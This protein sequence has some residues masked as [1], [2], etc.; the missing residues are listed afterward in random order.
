M[1]RPPKI[2]FDTV[3]TFPFSSRISKLPCIF[4]KTVDG[5]L[6]RLG[7]S[8]SPLLFFLTVVS[9]PSSSFTTIFPEKSS[10]IVSLIP[11]LF[12][13]VYSPRLPRLNLMVF[14]H[15]SERI[16]SPQLSVSI[17][18]DFLSKP[19]EIAILIMYFFILSEGGSDHIR[20]YS[21]TVEILAS[22]VNVTNSSEKLNKKYIRMI[23][24]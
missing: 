18:M 3:F 6:S 23:C 17:F 16:T 13:V 4:L 24:L 7:R 8:K 1:S 20:V 15:I 19:S 9:P 5:L 21:S 12:T 11:L 14:L 2:F 10:F 22:E